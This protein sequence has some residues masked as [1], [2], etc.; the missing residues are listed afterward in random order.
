[1]EIKFITGQIFLWYLNPEN[2]LVFKV[3]DTVLVPFVGSGSECV[4]AVS[5]GRGFVGFEL[6]SLDLFSSIS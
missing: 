5:E 4:A 6:N 3:G 1:M 2:S